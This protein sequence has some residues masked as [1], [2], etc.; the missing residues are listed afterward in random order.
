MYTISSNRPTRTKTKRAVKTPVPVPEPVPEPEPEL[1]PLSPSLQQ[2][3]TRHPQVEAAEPETEGEPEDRLV[4]HTYYTNDALMNEILARSGKPFHLPLDSLPKKTKKTKKFV[5]TLSTIRP[6]PSHAS[7]QK[8]IKRF[9]HATATRRRSTYLQTICSDAGVCVAFGLEMKRLTKFFNFLTFRFAKSITPIGTPSANGFVRLIEFVR[10]R[11][12][13]HAV[14]K[15]SQT[16]SADNLA[17]EYSVGHYINVCALSYPCFVLT[18]GLYR[19][20][21]VDSKE[22]SLRDPSHSRI[23]LNGDT[24]Y[25]GICPGNIC[26]TP[27]MPRFTMQDACHYSSRLCILIQY[28]NGSIP[29]RDKFRPF[30]ADFYNTDALFILYIIYYTLFNL[31]TTFTHYD[32]HPGNVLLYEPIAGSYI[33]YN[34]VSTGV[35]FKSRY[36]P[37]IIDYGQSFHPHGREFVQA[38]RDQCPNNGI[39]HGFNHASLDNRLHPNDSYKNLARKNESHDL[40]LLSI[41]KYYMRSQ[42]VTPLTQLLN[43]VV[44]TGDYGTDEITQSD[45]VR[46]YNVTDAERQL[47]SLIPD[48]MAKNDADYA[49][50]TRIGVLNIYGDRPMVFE[51]MRHE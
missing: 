27:M 39:H 34:I 44:F 48:A 1:S 23:Y 25:P 30:D 41:L 29:L 6:T 10:D 21:S 22:V 2:P 12:T 15:S 28:L 5:P 43:R 32:L 14:L 26:L 49:P 17:V 33:E 19:Y 3:L 24:G 46:I 45:T 16:S 9:M 7:A 51:D 31:R 50:L 37:K 38:A 40:R 35:R 11:Y 8:T 13:S 4:T 47:R 42:P 20:S 36:L 18:Y